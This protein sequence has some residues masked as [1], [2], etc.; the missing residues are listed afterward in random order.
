MD[1][2]WHVVAFEV[3]NFAVLVALLQR[4]LFRPVQRAIAARR[5]ELEKANHEAA[6]REQA[7]AL[8]RKTY[9][10]RLQ[11]LEDESH[12]R[13]ETAIA[14]GRERADALV[15]EGREQA[16]HLVSAAEQQMVSARRHALEQL[17]VDVLRLAAEAAG[18]VVGNL[19]VAAIAAA[20]ARRGAHRLAEELTDGVPGPIQV[21]VG[22]GVDIEE[23]ERELHAV[24][25]PTVKLD[26]VVDPKIVAGARLRVEGHEVEASVSASLRRWYDE[27][28]DDPAL[29]ESGM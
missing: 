3:I 1:I 19:D 25:G 23:I 16:Q 9:E 15:V 17:R 13:M 11:A 12:A 29:Q 22:Q 27:Q 6:T 18:R 5:D 20:Y 26:M 10:Q 8:A 21:A 4:F 24:L 28:L 7:A 14:E 2:E